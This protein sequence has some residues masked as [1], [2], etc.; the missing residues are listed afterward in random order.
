MLT[1]LKFIFLFFYSFFLTIT[2]TFL[3][4]KYFFRL[5]I[6]KYVSLI[7]YYKFAFKR[8]LRKD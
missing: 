8:L 6:Y 4:L 3:L 1:I 5:E 7:D 2:F